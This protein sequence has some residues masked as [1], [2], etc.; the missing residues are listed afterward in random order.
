MHQVADGSRGVFLDSIEGLKY[1]A[2]G[3]EI[4]TSFTSSAI[5]EA[6]EATPTKKAKPAGVMG[7]EIRIKN[8]VGPGPFDRVMDRT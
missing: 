2:P 3:F 7:A 6:D 5:G 1:M 8:T 4:K